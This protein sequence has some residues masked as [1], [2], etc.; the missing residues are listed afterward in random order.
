VDARRSG[1]THGAWLRAFVPI[2]E[3]RLRVTVYL[4]EGLDLA[5]AQSFW[6][7]VTGVPQ[8]QFGKAYRAVA[9]PTIRTNKHE[10][11]CAYVKYSCARVHRMVMGLVYALLSSSA[12]P[13]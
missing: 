7:S 13:G 9:D 3:G 10:F 6:S 8:S 5:E 2:D 1:S 4:H 11:G 12:I